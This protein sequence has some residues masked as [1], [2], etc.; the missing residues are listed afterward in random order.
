MEAAVEGSENSPTGG[1]FGDMMP[2]SM[3]ASS[4]GLAEARSSP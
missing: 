1:R 4:D 3:Q 2:R